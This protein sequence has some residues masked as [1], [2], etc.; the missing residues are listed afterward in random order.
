MPYEP[1]GRV[2]SRAAAAIPAEAASTEYTLGAG[3]Q[4][5]VDVFGVADL[6]GT[7]YTLLSDGSLT[8]PWVGKVVLQGLTTEKASET[9]V[10]RYR[11]YIHRPSITVSLVSP[12]PV[13][14]GVVGEVNRP[15][16]YTT[17]QSAGG[18]IEGDGAAAPIRTVTQAIQAAGGIT[19]LAD[20]RN[21]EIRRPQLG[22]RQEVIRVDLWAFLQAGELDQD[23]PLR[24]GD[25]L[26]VP[27]VSALDPR[28]AV[29]LA[30]A[31]FS[32]ETV[33][34]N[35]V[36]E[37]KSPGTLALQSNTSLNQAIL[38]AGGFDL[39]RARTSEVQLIRINPDGS[40]VRREIQV[41]L[42]AEVNEAT[43]PA[44]RNN[45]IVVVGRSG[46]ARTG[47]FLN[48]LL[49]PINPFVGVFSILRIFGGN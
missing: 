20:I 10:Q 11:R 40:A 21:I 49:G 42:S 45:D 4:V 24:D 48:T 33:R 26:I 6:S 16:A 13:R 25:T 31:N 44:L 39:T 35:V 29:Q 37:V 9:L 14:I 2:P 30:A 5:R 46:L 8:L 17:G 34:I 22:N 38:A 32:P 19:Q 18:T 28:E 41:D 23:I 47:D 7:T 12:R 15:G 27:T 3:D 36:G 43:N 1:S